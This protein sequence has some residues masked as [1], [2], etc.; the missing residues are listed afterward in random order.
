MLNNETDDPNMPEWL[1]KIFEKRRKKNMGKRIDLS[2]YDWWCDECDA[3][4][5]DQPG[6]SA[7]CGCW[8]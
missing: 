2:D 8:I 3:S 1:K 7:D 5:N 6:F 4:L